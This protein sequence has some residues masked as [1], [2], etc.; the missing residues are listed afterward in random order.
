MFCK[1]TCL[2]K[3]LVIKPIFVVC[4]KN[5]FLLLVF[6]IDHIIISI[7]FY[8]YKKKY[9]NYIIKNKISISNIF[10]YSIS[11]N[12]LIFCYK[13]LTKNLRRKINLLLF[14]L[15]CFYLYFP[16]QVVCSIRP[17]YCLHLHKTRVVPD[18][19]LA[20]YPAN[21]FSGYRISG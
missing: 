17:L 3:F 12:I 7:S 20:G 4:S 13:K 6:Y 18:T 1:L 10:F 8:F 15:S 14:F 16:Y 21:N 5:L 9:Q 2:L 11:L 19:D